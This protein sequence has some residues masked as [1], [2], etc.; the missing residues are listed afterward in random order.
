MTHQTESKIKQ[1]QERKASQGH[2]ILRYGI[3]DKLAERVDQV[4]G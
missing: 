1:K 3:I 2:G 4:H